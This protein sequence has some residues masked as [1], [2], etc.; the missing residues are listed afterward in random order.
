MGERE[1]PPGAPDIPTLYSEY[2]SKKQSY[3]ADA[4]AKNRTLRSKYRQISSALLELLRAGVRSVTAEQIT[5]HKDISYFNNLITLSPKAPPIPSISYSGATTTIAG[6]EVPSMPVFLFT[7]PTV[8]IENAVASALASI[9]VIE[10]DK[11]SPAANPD[12]ENAFA[13]YYRFSVFSAR[14][15]GITAIGVSLAL[16]PLTFEGSVTIQN[17]DILTY[18][19]AIE[20]RRTISDAYN[21]LLLDVGLTILTGTLRTSLQTELATTTQIDLPV[22]AMMFSASAPTSTAIQHFKGIRVINTKCAGRDIAETQRAGLLLVLRQA[23]FAG[24]IYCR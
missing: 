17:T 5:I 12:F 1:T 3:L 14:G 4:F 20:L 9:I 8:E 13:K 2:S 22:V 15:G 7:T 19:Q 11:S 18:D 24:S 10:V 16:A 23:G 6:K 21:N